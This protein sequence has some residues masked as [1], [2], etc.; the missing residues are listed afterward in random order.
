[1]W[2]VFTVLWAG[3]AWGMAEESVFY[4]GTYHKGEAGR[5]IQ[6][7]SLD[8]A[9]GKLGPVRLATE[10]PNPSFLAAA[11]DG[12]TVY[13][14]EEGTPSRVG[15]YAVQP[16]GTLKRLNSV[17]SEGGGA[18]HVWAGGQHV[19][20]SNY[21]GGTIACFPIRPDGSLGP[22][23]SVVAFT[24]SGPNTGRQEKSHAHA[25]LTD[26]RAAFAYACDLG[27]D[28]V[29]SFAFDAA[30][31]TLRATEPPAGKTDPGSG[32]R[33]MA[34][35]AGEKFL[36]VNNELTLTVTVFARDP[37]SGVLKAIQTLGRPESAGPWADQSTS[38]EIQMHPNGKWLYVS[39]R[40]DDS[41]SLFS[42]AEDG[43]LAWVE[44]APAQVAVPRGFS[45]DP[46]GRW[47]VA[48]GQ[49]DNRIVVLRIDPGTGKLAATGESAEVPA[50]VCVLFAP[51]RG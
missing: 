1:M 14:A 18:C 23:S 44:N 36:Y 50:P 25:M 29:W 31:G 40:R 27:S 19:F 4:L 20:V 2:R 45:L 9:S 12:K 15:A 34:W 48:A 16:D 10:A 30:K 32:P 37:A 28:S 51:P 46:S 8:S 26:A 39:N 6:M 5:G 42:V 17:P 13:A 33:H 11:P 24:G 7:G 49:K 3:L 38:S 41:I 47:L 43:R 22:A 21:G 35:G